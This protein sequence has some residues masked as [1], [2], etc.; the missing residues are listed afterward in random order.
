MYFNVARVSHTQ[1]CFSFWKS[2][3]TSLN[4]WSLKMLS[5]FTCSFLEEI[6]LFK[7]LHIF[8]QYCQFIFSILPF[9]RNNCSCGFLA[10]LRPNLACYI[11]QVKSQ[12]NTLQFKPNSDCGVC[13]INKHNL[14]QLRDY[15]RAF[16]RGCWGHWSHWS[17]G[18][19]H[20]RCFRRWLICTWMWQAAFIH[21]NT[22]V[23]LTW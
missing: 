7:Y 9:K 17:Q 14:L 18:G 1:F 15:S 6:L 22:T 11:L 2:R 8:I 23:L 13:Y 4:P 5:S 16:W 10:Y 3:V 20:I 21:G 12:S 19:T